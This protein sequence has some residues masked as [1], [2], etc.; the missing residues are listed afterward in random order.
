MLI[1]QKNMLIKQEQTEKPTSPLLFWAMLFFTVYYM[2]LPLSSRIYPSGYLI[3]LSLLAA[4]LFFYLK[5]YSFILIST[6]PLLNIPIFWLIALLYA[7]FNEA[8]LRSAFFTDGLSQL[9]ILIAFMFSAMSTQKWIKANDQLVLFFVMLHSFATILFLAFPNL[10]GYYAAATYP[11]DYSSLMS[12]YSLGRLAGLCANYSTNGIYLSLGVGIVGCRFLVAKQRNSVQVLLNL[13]V[14]AALL[15]TGKRGPLIF[16]AAALIFTYLVMNRRQKI[17]RY[18]KVIAAVAVAIV[19]FLIAS[20]YIPALGKTLERMIAGL[21]S[22]DITGG[23][24][25]LYQLAIVMFHENPVFGCGWGS[26]QY[27]ADASVIGAIYGRNSDMYAHNCYLQLLAETGIVGFVLFVGAIFLTLRAAVKVVKAIQADPDEVPN[28]EKMYFLATSL[29]VQI[30]F[31]LYCL[32]G[33]PLYDYPSLF[34]YLI[35]STVPLAI[36]RGAQKKKEG[37]G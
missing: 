33:N 34:P 36:Y 24:M 14:V 18:F 6:R 25:I 5:T 22:D 31:I 4:I 3:P 9:A 2:L 23:R 17:K 15:L 8:L 13:C 30:F 11:G 1:N 32:T 12:N 21:S 27:R 10:Y 19:A 16:S 26:Y 20:Y 35:F 37:L 29:Y 7:V 28:G